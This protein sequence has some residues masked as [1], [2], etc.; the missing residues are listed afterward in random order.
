MGGLVVRALIEDPGL[1]PRNVRQL[2]MVAPPTHGSILARFGFALDLAEHIANPERR[3]EIGLLS[4]MVEDGLSEATGDLV[5]GSP[6]LAR[7]NDR[8]RNDE[9]Q[10]TVFLGTKGLVDE[11]RMSEIRKRVAAAGL[12]NRW[13]Q[14][15]GPKVHGWLEDLDEVVEGRGDGVVAVK[16]GLLDHVEDTVV[17]HFGHMGVLRAH[18][19][20]DVTK[21]HEGIYARL[22]AIPFN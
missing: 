19:S 9:V 2:I 18:F 14:F 4:A 5:P 16:R 20:D 15:F 3:K 13:T 22:S 17:L 6:F 1:D 21:V 12:N 8:D 11:Q 7:L 10:Y